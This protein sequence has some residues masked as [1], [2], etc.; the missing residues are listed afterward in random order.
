MACRVEPYILDGIV[1][2]GAKTIVRLY[3]WVNR[4]RLGDRPGKVAGRCSMSQN[5]DGE[6]RSLVSKIVH[7][8]VGWWG[9]EYGE[10]FFGEPI[11]KTR[12]DTLASECLG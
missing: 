12:N 9:I 6:T 11:L 5:R 10:I 8:K 7:T 1:W 2:L 4:N 3:G